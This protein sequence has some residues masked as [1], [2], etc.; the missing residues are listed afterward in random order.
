VRARPSIVALGAVLWLAAPTQAGDRE[1]GLPRASEA[2]PPGY[3][4]QL[5]AAVRARLDALAAAHGPKLVPP[6][7]V[8]VKWK[9]VKLGS[10]D[11]GA[12]LVALAA[13]DLDGD[14]RGELYAVTPRQ[15]IAIGFRNGRALE[16]GRVAFTGDRAVPAP[17]DVVGTAVVEG[18]ELVAAASPW[19]RELRVSWRNRTLIAQPGVSPYLVCPGERTQLEPG[20]NY[21]VNGTYAVRCRTD[22]VDAQGTALR[23]RGELAKTGKLAVVVQKCPAAAACQQVASFEYGNVGV[24]FELADVD[25]DGTPEVV[26]SEA[27]APGATDGVKVMSLGGDDKKPRFR[28]SFN[29][30]V[31]GLVAVD[32]D[33]S[34]TA[35]VIAATRFAGSTRVDLWRL[36]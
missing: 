9:V 11:L 24:A 14:K 1:P 12:P 31:A 26:V 13:A 36:D 6:T 2:P 21:F 33:G 19:S 16:L 34:G 10:I 25:H 18:S 17:R 27:S 4:A 29:G 35:E 32:G 22:L 3:L 23:V 20:R 30:G 28:R 8:A 7:P 5:A 15:V